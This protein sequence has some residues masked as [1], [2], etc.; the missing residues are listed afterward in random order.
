MKKACKI[1]GTVDSIT[2]EKVTFRFTSEVSATLSIRS[3]LF[4]GGGWSF[5]ITKFEVLHEKIQGVGGD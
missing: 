4:G 5:E 2:K 1:H 3:S